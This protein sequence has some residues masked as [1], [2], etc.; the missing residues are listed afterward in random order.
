LLKKEVYEV[1]QEQY[2]KKASDYVPYAERKLRE[3]IRQLE[4]KVDSLEEQL[5]YL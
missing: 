4:I 1:A 3:E 5:K 2:N